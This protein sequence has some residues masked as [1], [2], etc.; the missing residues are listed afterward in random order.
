MDLNRLF[1]H[2]ANLYEVIDSFEG[3]HHMKAPAS[4]IMLQALFKF[5]M[6]VVTMEE[7]N[8]HSEVVAIAQICCSDMWRASRE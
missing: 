6:G 4:G 7:H 8:H 3:T 5:G 1:D 2:P